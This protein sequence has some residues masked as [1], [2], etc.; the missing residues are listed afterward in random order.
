MTLNRVIFDSENLVMDWIEFNIQGL[1]NRKQ[2]ER[3]ARYLFQ[4]C[5][6]NST[7]ALGSNGKQETLFCNF[8][9]KYQISFRAYRYSNIY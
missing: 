9:N 5:V 3:I 2:V 1:V 8:K 6:V 4:N 7:F